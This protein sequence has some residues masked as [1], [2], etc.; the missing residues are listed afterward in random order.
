[1]CLLNDDVCKKLSLLDSTVKTTVLEEFGNTGKVSKVSLDL[2]RITG[3]IC[4][5]LVNEVR[6]RSG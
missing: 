3:E 4:H 6:W 1:M 5:I 2:L